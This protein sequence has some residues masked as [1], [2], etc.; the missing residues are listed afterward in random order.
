M[1]SRI[2]QE[3]E[4]EQIATDLFQDLFRMSLQRQDENKV[5]EVGEQ[6]LSLFVT[7]KDDIQQSIWIEALG[8]SVHQIES[9][10]MPS[11]IIPGFSQ[12][13]R[14]N[15]PLIQYLRAWHRDHKEPFPFQNLTHCIIEDSACH[16]TVTGHKLFSSE[17]CA[18]VRKQVVGFFREENRRH[19]EVRIPELPLSPSAQDLTNAVIARQRSD[20][21]G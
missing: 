9:I 17:H 1:S 15:M 20:E 21:D 3:H 16:P 19:P 8:E 12:G 4:E 5:D 11:K 14:L 13:A 18:Y 7:Q 2:L 6:E 10:T